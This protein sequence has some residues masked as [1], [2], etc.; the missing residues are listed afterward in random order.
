[1]RIL[2]AHNFYQQSGG[3]DAVFFAEAALLEQFGHAPLRYVM[4]ND[5]ISQMS[6]LSVAGKTIWNRQVHREIADV[7]KSHNIDVVHFHNT[8]PLISPAAYSACRAA[9]AAVVQTLHNYRTICPGA[10][11]F[12]D[13]HDCEECLGR[14]FKLP[15]IKHKCYRGSLS[16]T[17]VLTAS[18]AYHHHR[19]TFDNDVDL[20]IT[21]SESTRQRFLQAGMKAEQVVVKPHFVSPDPGEGPGGNYAVFCGRL[22][23]EK[24]VG[25]LLAAWKKLGGRVPLKIIGD[26]PMREDVIQ[27]AKT[28]SSIEWLGRRAMPEVY[29]I[30]GGAA[31]A[32]IPSHVRET[33]GRVA[34]EAFATGTPVIAAHIGALAELITEGTGATFE[35]ANPDDLA[36][37]V[38][39]FL[40][41]PV[42]LRAMRRDCRREFLAHY[43]GEPNHRM[44]ID[45]YDRAIALKQGTQACHPERYP[46]KDLH[47]E[48][49]QLSH[50]DP[51]P[52]TAQDDTAFGVRVDLTNLKPTPP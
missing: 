4:H 26:G 44:L 46:A 20:Y 41:N 23:P 7:V 6:R 13:G 48:V 14:K 47:P 37:C 9:G 1:M 15:A 45:I 27:A 12:R 40:A 28:D 17:A 42:R 22:S 35:P 25:S 50:R 30:L 29:D 21:P 32:I 43:T 36:A 8:F 33:F 31:V 2:L 39:E 52:S 3:E 5:Q 11:L 19:G 49:A 24:G 34:I 10:L 51:S 38:E 18:L 16:A